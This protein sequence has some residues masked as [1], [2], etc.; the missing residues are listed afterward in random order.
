MIDNASS[1][2]HSTWPQ[3]GYYD[4]NHHFRKVLCSLI[5]EEVSN[6]YDGRVLTDQSGWTLLDR[7]SLAPPL[8]SLGCSSWYHLQ[9]RFSLRCSAVVLSRG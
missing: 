9:V 5:E 2:A 3:T 1:F 7:P 6:N 8:R 4:N